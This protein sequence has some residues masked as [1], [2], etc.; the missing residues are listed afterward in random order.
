MR[1]ACCTAEATRHGTALRVPM[2]ACAVQCVSSPTMVSLRL[3]AGAER[4]CSAH[5]LEHLQASSSAAAAYACKCARFLS[6]VRNANCA[7]CCGAQAGAQRCGWL[8]CHDL[9]SMDIGPVV[10]SVEAKTTTLERSQD[11]VYVQRCAV[12]AAVEAVGSSTEPM[13]RGRGQTPVPD[14]LGSP[15]LCS[16]PLFPVVGGWCR[17]PVQTARRVSAFIVQSMKRLGQCREYA[18]C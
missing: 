18:L 16:Q 7:W 6:S 15:P 3:P 17:T 2:A 10:H 8:A 14:S 5:L 9:V 1:H 11:P 4:S 13:R 12:V